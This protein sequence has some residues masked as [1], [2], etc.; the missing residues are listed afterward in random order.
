M[1]ILIIGALFLYGVFMFYISYVSSKKTH[2]DATEYFVAGRSV[3]PIAL[4]GTMCLSIWSALAF[5]GYGAGLY[6]Q[7]VGYFSGAVGAYFVGLYAP[8]IQYRLWILGKKYGY[9]TPGDFFQHRYN[10]RIFTLI[11]AAINVIFIIPYIALQIIGVAD[12]VNIVSSGRIGF[13]VVVAILTVY[14]VFHILKG[15][16]NSVVNTDIMAGFCGVGIAIITTIIFIK[17]V[18]GNNNGLAYATKIITETSPN[19]LKATGE[20]STWYGILGLAI[21]AGMSIIA[22]PHIFVRSYMAKSESVFKVM[23]I[24]FPLLELLCFGQF[25]LQGIW[26]GKVAYPGLTGVATDRLIPM[27]ALNYAPTIMSALLVI[28]V[29]AF[30]MSTADSQIVV[31]SSVIQK[32]IFREKGNEPN[33]LKKTRIWIVAMMAAILIVVKYRPALLVDYAYKF[34]A[35]GFAQLVPA[36]FG[37]LYWKKATK[38]GAISGTMVGLAAVLGT[39]FIN[40]PIKGVHPILWGLTLNT[41]VFILISLVTKNDEKAVSEIVDYFDTIFAAQNNFQHKIILCC[42]AIAFVQMIITPYLPN[43]ILFGWMPG[44]VFN[45]VLL[46]FEVSTIGYFLGKNRFKATEGKK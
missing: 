30:G 10:S 9:I 12:G 46:A 29:F 25:A 31:S 5:F 19:T 35:P 43:I 34:S 26:V 2:G 11:T 16:S 45:Y 17:A 18:L 7:G 39:L 40:N 14:I 1:S 36:M 42:I 3:G 8:T 41:I 15:G 4:L 20:Y 6:R 27:I 13:W 33:T 22:W 44:Q 37:G 24:A 32:D 21:S 23:S 38:E 28:G